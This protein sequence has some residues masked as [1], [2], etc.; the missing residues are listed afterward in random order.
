MPLNTEDSLLREEWRIRLAFHHRR[1]SNSKTDQRSMHS[2]KAALFWSQ[3]TNYR[4]SRA[5]EQNPMN[6][7]SSAS[8]T[9][10]KSTVSK[11]FIP[12]C[13]TETGKCSCKRPSVSVP[14]DGDSP[15]HNTPSFWSIHCRTN[16]DETLDCKDNTYRFAVT[17]TFRYHRSKLDGSKVLMSCRDPDSVR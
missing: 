13:M 5:C 4:S 8:N 12:K 16:R 9:V 3:I 2:E 7:K 11:R 10:W 1:S 17:Q 6:L 14:R 15:I